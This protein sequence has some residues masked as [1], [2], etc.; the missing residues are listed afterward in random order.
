M[1]LT[2]EILLRK[3][4]REALGEKNYKYFAK[5]AER[6]NEMRNEDW[7]YVGNCIHCNVSMYW[8][9]DNQKLKALDSD[10]DCIHEL[11][12]EKENDKT[13]SSI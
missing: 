9:E 2:R 11:A 4:L 6:R 1:K 13:D 12:E 3:A 8:S 7:E 10:I 5:L